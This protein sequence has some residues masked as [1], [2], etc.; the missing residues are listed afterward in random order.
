MQEEKEMRLFGKFKD[1]K[2]QL[3]QYAEQEQQGVPL[4][5]TIPCNSI[6]FPYF[7]DSS[8]NEQPVRELIDWTTDYMIKR[9]VN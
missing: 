1:V 9:S 7:N 5:G 6:M 2:K 8:H 4:P 3:E